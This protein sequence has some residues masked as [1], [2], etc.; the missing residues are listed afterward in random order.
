[1]TSG[2]PL[3]PALAARILG[4]SLVLLALLVLVTTLIVALLDGPPE[5]VLGM[6]VL[7]VV[8]VFA[9]IH[10]LRRRL[11]VIELDD[12]AYR[13]RWVRGA[14]VRT[15]RWGEVAEAV[16]MSPQG[17]DCVV[18]RLTDGR[19]TIVPVAVVAAPREELVEAL[20]EHLRRARG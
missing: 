11:H 17:V 13:V 7:A 20:R 6:G 18:L 3:A 14:G 16:A 4:G 1:V 9:L 2:Y 12:V 15:A 8:V 5:V 19:T 10:L